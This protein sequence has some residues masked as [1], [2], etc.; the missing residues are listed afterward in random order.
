MFTSMT[1]QKFQFSRKQG[2]NS[3]LTIEIWNRVNIWST[4]SLNK[5]N[6]LPLKQ[7]KAFYLTASYCHQKITETGLGGVQCDQKKIA[8]CLQKLPKNDFTRK[9]IDFDTFTKIA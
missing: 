8:K 2:S 6:H 4:F 3:I 7:L 5:I 9:M 1:S